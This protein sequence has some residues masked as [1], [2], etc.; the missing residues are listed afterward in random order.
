MKVIV[1]FKQVNPTFNKELPVEIILG[2]GNGGN[3]KEKIVKKIILEDVDT[4]DINR[5]GAYRYMGPGKQ[6]DDSFIDMVIVEVRGEK[7]KFGFMFGA[8]KNLI[9]KMY[10]RYDKGKDSM[11]FYF[12]FKPEVA[13]IEVTEDVFICKDDLP[14]ALRR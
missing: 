2:E 11:R 12:Y 5:K 13:Y 6:T 3:W 1:T 7:R 4:I 10:K 9:E 14:E 8:A